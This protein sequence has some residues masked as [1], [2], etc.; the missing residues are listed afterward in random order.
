MHRVFHNFACSPCLC[1]TS[2][3]YLPVICRSVMQHPAPEQLH[4]EATHCMDVP[5]TPPLP[6]PLHLLT[7]PALLRHIMHVLLAGCSLPGGL[8]LAAVMPICRR[9]CKGV[10]DLIWSVAVEMRVAETRGC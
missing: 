4:H 9:C 8:R 5:S 6:L 1:F 3:A 10:W 2:D 7:A